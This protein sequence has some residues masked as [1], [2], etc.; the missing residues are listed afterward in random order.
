MAKPPRPPWCDMKAAYPV[1]NPDRLWRAL[2]RG[3]LDLPDGW[4]LVETDGSGARYVAL[5]RI[6]GVPTVE[7]G[8][9]V[10]A[11]VRR[12]GR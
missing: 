6:A 7:D 1:T 5:F 11:T 3:A 8:R 9:R 10:A 12:F 2:D 4:S